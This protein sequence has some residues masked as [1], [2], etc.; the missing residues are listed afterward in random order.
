MWT[1]LI[2]ALKEI[3]DLRAKARDDEK[4]TLEIKK[5]K[6]EQSSQESRIVPATMEEI[7]KYNPKYQ[8]IR[9]A[10]T[11]AKLIVPILVLCAF[12]GGTRY[13]GYREE[14]K[15]S[16]APPLLRSNIQIGDNDDNDDYPTRVPGALSLQET[17]NRAI[18]NEADVFR[19][20]P[21]LDMAV[22][23]CSISEFVL[24]DEYAVV[25]DHWTVSGSGFSHGDR[26]PHNWYM[27]APWTVRTPEGNTLVWTRNINRLPPDDVITEGTIYTVL[28]IEDAWGAL[29]TNSETSDLYLFNRFRGMNVPLDTNIQARW[30]RLGIR[31]IVRFSSQPITNIIAILPGAIL[32][33]TNGPRSQ[34]NSN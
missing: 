22:S 23:E 7:E 12:I 8:K 14:I 27:S 1:L 29:S 19:V 2:N 17:V 18:W 5:L 20:L 33:S 9:R 16:N 30:P 21:V 25:P 13:S 31:Q 10:L 4:T 32:K 3:I 15:S 11:S 24:I 28:P 26:L 6:V 34:L